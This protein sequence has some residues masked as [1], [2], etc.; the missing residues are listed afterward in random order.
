MPS[1]AAPL[2]TTIAPAT[3]STPATLASAT[4]ASPASLSVQPA[5]PAQPAGVPATPAVL[6]AYQAA[7]TASEADVRLA[8]QF[9]FLTADPTPASPAPAEGATD[10]TDG[11]EITLEAVVEPGEVPPV[12]PAAEVA[13]AAPTDEISQLKAKLAE[14]ESRVLGKQ[15][16][17]AV[18]GVAPSAPAL[19]VL[20]PTKESPL[21]NLRAENQ[22]DATERAA[23][24]LKQW[25]IQNRD[26]G[27]V[28]VDIAQ[29]AENAEA[30]RNGRAPRTVNEPVEIS[31]ELA[32][33]IE[34]NAEEM[35][36]EHIPQRRAFLAEQQAAVAAVKKSAPAVFDVKTEPGQLAQLFLSQLPQLTQNPNWPFIIRDLVTG[37]QANHKPAAASAA[38]SLP[39][40]SSPA[41]AAPKPK[42]TAPDVTGRPI[43]IAPA[44]PIGHSA[45]GG[46]PVS[47]A[48]IN[49]SI[50]AMQAGDRSEE[51]LAPLFALAM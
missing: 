20:A 33:N 12:E 2:E 10:G 32:A 26:G 42:A 49:A 1:A 44:A 4:S 25:V 37:Y 3:V 38:P 23:R 50:K 27:T 34:A 11:G 15:E 16:E 35:L 17:P 8:Q 21:V 40:S 46:V 30:A 7:T 22:L 36:T 47:Q 43:P 13:P 28:P 39:V 45:P 29:A 18:S 48:Q 6:T 5:S 41:P 31:R 9:G 14:L 19:P 24:Q 51:N